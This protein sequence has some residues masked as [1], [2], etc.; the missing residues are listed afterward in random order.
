MKHVVW[1]GLLLLWVWSWWSGH[2]SGLL[3]LAVF[4]LGST[5]LVLFVM[6]RLRAIDEENSP[7]A[8]FH[9]RTLVYIP[10]LLLQIVKANVDVSRRILSPSL[11]IQRRLIRVRPTQRTQ[12]GLVVFANSITLTP[13]TVSVI[14]DD[15]EL[16]VHA[17][18]D[19]AAEDLLTGEMDRRVSAWEGRA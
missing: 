1:L 8:W 6:H 9:P 3:F 13:G 15:D 7:L 17:L 12:V 16:L 10:W 11:P 19:E 4:P 18:C 2:F 14:V 5:A